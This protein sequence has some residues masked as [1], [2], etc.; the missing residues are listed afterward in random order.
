MAGMLFILFITSCENALNHEDAH[1]RVIT[2]VV[3]D[4]VIVL[5]TVYQTEVITEVVVEIVRDTVRE[6]DTIYLDNRGNRI[7]FQ[8]VYLT[9]SLSIQNT[10]AIVLESFHNNSNLTFGLEVQ[11]GASYPDQD[12]SFDLD[13]EREE[14][15]EE[16]PIFLS[17]IG[18]SADRVPFDQKV[19]VAKPQH[20]MNYHLFLN[21]T[22]ATDMQVGN[23]PQVLLHVHKF[24]IGNEGDI[25]F[26]NIESSVAPNIPEEIFLYS[27]NLS[28][29]YKP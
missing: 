15:P 9:E 25:Y 8:R 14:Y 3:K 17:Y 16:I 20:R 6:L 29:F 13:F 2:E 26:V 4:T 21:D 7:D 18:L 28:F 24:N 10:P 12:F 1:N 23:Q 27:Y 11:S 22:E 5:D 19:N